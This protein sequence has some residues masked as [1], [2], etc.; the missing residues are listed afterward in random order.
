MANEEIN[1]DYEVTLKVR[2]SKP[3]ETNNVERDEYKADN[4]WYE[5]IKDDVYGEVL[6]DPHMEIKEVDIDRIW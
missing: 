3:Y 5:R 1:L 2:V 4:Y 6:D